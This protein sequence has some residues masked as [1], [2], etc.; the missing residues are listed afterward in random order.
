[1]NEEGISYSRSGVDID[2]TDAIKRSLR[3]FVDV[4]DGRVLNRL[5]AF[6]S[7]V[8]G[9]FDGFREP[10]L[11]LKTEEPGTKQHLAFERQRWQGIGYD[12]INHLIN[13]IAVMGARPLYLQ[14]CI[15]CGEPEREVIAGLVSI[16]ADACRVQGC[17]L[18]GGETSVQ[19]GAVKAGRYFL[20]ASGIGIVER[21]AVVDGSHIRTG[22]VVLGIASNGLHTNGYSLVR[23][24]LARDPAIA[25]TDLSGETFLDVIMR[26]HLCY[27]P[28][29]ANVLP[30][31]D[32]HGLAHITGGGI[33]DNL[34][35]VLPASVDAVVD[36]A[37]IE[38]PEVFAF[39]RER[40][41][42][43]A[44]EMLR[45][46]NLGVG[47]VAVVDPSVVESCIRTA[48]GCN[49]RS[50]PIGRIGPGTGTV[51]FTNEIDW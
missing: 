21:S 31:E 16:M 41:G 24:L 36:L 34:R 49:F 2:A 40:A 43:S 47:L 32:V 48:A 1:M 17:I 18:T 5:G 37:E 9:R 6:G 29:V 26:P 23:T 30:S 8:Q 25:E 14:D 13:D 39:I 46:F 28:F 38:A 42:C 15:I 3:A 44:D 27:Y 33:A 50:W 22:D 51:Q 10:V 12:L 20:T 35:R 19:P 7:L 4:G 11:V 45:T